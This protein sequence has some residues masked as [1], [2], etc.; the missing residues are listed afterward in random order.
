MFEKITVHLE[1]GKKLLINSP[2]NSK[3]TRYISDFR[4]NGKTYTKNYVKHQD[5]MGGARIDVQMSDK[6]NKTRG[7]LKSDFPYSFSNENK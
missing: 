7:T 4:L 6:P 3:L 1:N 5:L 2:G